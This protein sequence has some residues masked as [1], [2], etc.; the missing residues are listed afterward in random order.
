MAMRLRHTLLASSILVSATMSAFISHRAVPTLVLARLA[1]AQGRDD[2]FNEKLL[3]SFTFR[4]V[5]PFRMQAR[6]SAIAV[7]A[8]TA[9]E[10]LYT[11]YLATWT[12]GVFKTTNGGATFKP[13]F[14]GQNKLTIGAIAVA[15]S[16]PAIV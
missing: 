14:D 1:A 10:H 13:V 2:L 16:N 12:G 4:N 5:G 6:A 11:F 9:N 15:P 3:R 8:S 7:P